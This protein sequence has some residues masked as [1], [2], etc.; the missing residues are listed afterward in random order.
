MSTI[1]AVLRGGYIVESLKAGQHSIVSL[2]DLSKPFDYVSH[3]LSVKKLYFYGVRGETSDIFRSHICLIRMFNNTVSDM[4]M[5][6][7]GI[8][9]ESI[10]ET[11]LFI[12][13]TNYL[14]FYMSTE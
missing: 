8:P 11:I 13:C 7:Y 5:V 14:Y 3:E 1:K 2:Y 6:Q 10:L 4:S 9:Q 12:I